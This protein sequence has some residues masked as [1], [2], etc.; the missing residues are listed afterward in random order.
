MSEQVY[1]DKGSK[2]RIRKIYWK[3]HEILSAILFAASAA[4]V[5]IGAAIWMMTHDI[6]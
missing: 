1:L 5:T 4:A 6:D 2:R 3:R